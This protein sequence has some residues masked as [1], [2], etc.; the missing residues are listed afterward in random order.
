MVSMLFREYEFRLRAASSRLL[1]K[2]INSVFVLHL[3][4]QQHAQGKLLT[5]FFTG[6]QSFYSTAANVEKISEQSEQ[7]PRNRY[8]TQQLFREKETVLLYS[9][10]M[11]FYC[12]TSNN[13]TF[14]Y[15]LQSGSS[16]IKQWTT[17]RY[18]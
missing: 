15:M 3:Q 11:L 17:N 12:F 7:Y 1:L 13:G 2:Y 9:G 18:C 8:T 10:Q 16:V 4:L 5:S 14:L 6:S